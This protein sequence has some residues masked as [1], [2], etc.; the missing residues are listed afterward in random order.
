MKDLIPEFK[1]FSDE[2]KERNEV[3]A[4]NIVEAARKNPS[5]RIVV[6]CGSEHRYMLRNLLAKDENLTLKE[7]YEISD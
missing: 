7:F 1:F 2:W 4:K 3:M 5:Q 6:L